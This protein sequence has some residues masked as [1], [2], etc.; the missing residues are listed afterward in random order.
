MSRR[1]TSLLAEVREAEESCL[2]KDSGRQKLDPSVEEKLQRPRQC[3]CMEK[4]WKI[5]QLAECRETGW[6]AW[7]CHFKIRILDSSVLFFYNFRFPMPGLAFSSHL[8]FLLSTEFIFLFCFAA[9]RGTT[10]D[11]QSHANILTTT[12][13]KCCS[14][15]LVFSQRFSR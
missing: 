2:R 13:Y 4:P 7:R 14:C 9:G 6:R 8:V 11:R 5:L 3:T 1:W 10:L 12:G 15:G